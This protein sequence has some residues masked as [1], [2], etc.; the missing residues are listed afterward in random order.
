M[1]IEKWKSYL[2]LVVP[3]AVGSYANSIKVDCLFF[4]AG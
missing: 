2:D 3:A 1:G 4:I